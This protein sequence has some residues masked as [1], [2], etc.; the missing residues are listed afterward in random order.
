M[1]LLLFKPE[2][3]PLILSGKKTSTIRKQ[4]PKPGPRARPGELLIMHTAPYTDPLENKIGEA[5]VDAIM[6]V[7]ICLENG[8]PVLYTAGKKTPEETPLY[9]AD[10]VELEEIV[11]KE[12]FTIEGV[13]TTHASKQAFFD[14]FELEKKRGILRMALRLHAYRRR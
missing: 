6:R 7:K 12:G 3:A 2:F 4:G 9:Q 8:Q 1:P 5:R 11:D 10:W 14:F 13:A